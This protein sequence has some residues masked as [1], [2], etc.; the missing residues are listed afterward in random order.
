[1]HDQEH[2]GG[3]R[4]WR[5]QE[6][7]RR[8]ATSSG[9]VLGN[10]VSPQNLIVGTGV[11]GLQGTEG[12]RLRMVLKWSIRP[13]GVMAILVVLRAYVL[14]FTV[15]YEARRELR[16]PAAAGRPRTSAACVPR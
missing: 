3:G 4:S 10:M 2:E 16:P 14:K 9:D 11:T 1:M 13:T 5:L 8:Y 7:P 15:A 12:D 6:T